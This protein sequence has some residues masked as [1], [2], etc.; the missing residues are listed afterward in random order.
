MHSRLMFWDSDL[1]RL[2]C[3]Y[4]LTVTMFTECLPWLRGSDRESGMGGAIC[5]WLVWPP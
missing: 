5:D 3:D 4:S 2:P 1:T